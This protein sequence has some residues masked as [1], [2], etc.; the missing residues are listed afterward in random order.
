MRRFWKPLSLGLMIFLFTLTTSVIG[1]YAFEFYIS[2]TDPEYDDY[3]WKY[4]R[5]PLPIS[6]HPVATL[7]SG[8]LGSMYPDLD[9]KGVAP[10]ETRGRVPESRVFHVRSN[11]FGFYTDYPVN[12]FPV[13]QANEFR[14]ILVGG[15]GA[16]GHGGSRNDR[17]MYKLVERALANSLA[18]TGYK[19]RVINLALAGGEAR[20]NSGI[21]REFGHRLEPD[22]IL[23]Y[24]GANDIA[25]FPRLHAEDACSEYYGSMMNSTYVAPDWVQ[26]F[27]AHFPALIYRYGLAATIKRRF[28]ADSYRQLAMGQCMRDLGV[29]TTRGRPM[30][31]LYR[32]GAAPMFV[33]HF[34]AIKRDFCG[35]PI[36]LAW[37]A[38]HD[39]ERALYDRWLTD[40][41][42]QTNP[43]VALESLNQAEASIQFHNPENRV[44]HFAIRG[45]NAG[46]PTWDEVIGSSDGYDQAEGRA[47]IPYKAAA[48]KADRVSAQ[49]S[50]SANDQQPAYVYYA[51]EPTLGDDSRSVY[52]AY[53]ESE[54]NTFRRKRGIYQKFIAHNEAALDGYLNRY[55]YFVNVDRVANAIDPATVA[56]MTPTSIAVHL[57]DV[58]QEIV[59]SIIA[60][61]LEPVVRDL[62]QTGNR[63]ACPN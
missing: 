33:T 3:W 58:G 20:T 12:E 45:R 2:A 19:V 9:Y 47:K 13:K 54:L 8:T 30:T 53:E 4:P 42:P 50:E 46:K 10:W 38:L 63:P 36:M 56:D 61:R 43:V 48:T 22:L 41:D 44:V 55:W 7:A 14:I 60:E 23:G 27:G 34:K 62:I 31:A 49:A 37:Q 57:D 25:Q 18:D 5:E 24:N 17:M 39:G 16:Q 59:A 35:I 29:D 6:P 26:A 51:M 15:S 11:R 52:L 21:L 1:L 28:Y 40:F 32:D